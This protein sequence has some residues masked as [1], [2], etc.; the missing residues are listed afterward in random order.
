MLLLLALLLQQGPPPGAKCPVLP[1]QRASAENSLIY[2]GRLIYFCCADCV[3]EFQADPKKYVKDPEAED[4]SFTERAI[5][6][7]R[8]FRDR[9]LRA[10]IFA[11]A[12]MIL[13]LGLARAARRWSA[14]RLLAGLSR[15]SL[16][17]FALLW[18]VSIHVA[19]LP[20]A[21]K[22]S[23]T[24]TRRLRANSVQELIRV[25]AAQALL[26]D[27]PGFVH[28]LG[29]TYY[30][31]N[32]ER[33]PKLFNNGNYQTCAFHVSLRNEAGRT[34]APGDAVGGEKLFLRLEIVR[35][36]NTAQGF[37]TSRA[38]E[39]VRLTRYDEGPDDPALNPD[40]ALEVIEENRRW[41]LLYPL[42][43]LAERKYSELR[44]HL[45]LGPGSAQNAQY[46]I[47]YVLLA[48]D[49]KLL[50]ESRLWM[51]ATLTL[52]FKD[53][54][55]DEWLSLKPLPTIPDPAPVSEKSR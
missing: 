39:R 55:M 25:S 12:A 19:A 45:I 2:E 35:A 23:P 38:M 7:A 15:R 1:D 11:G 24:E 13:H 50:K 42:G 43:K 49:G 44:G 40:Q 52:Q 47:P 20:N 14:S 29:G 6:G 32:N 18:G 37:Y 41:G 54:T 36:P 46:V 48:E 21:P 3:A 51:A 5:E 33:S 34:I 30:R 31:G 17:A 28:R 53:H 27:D 8:D 4:I 22:P 16:L 9:H 10:L 26:R